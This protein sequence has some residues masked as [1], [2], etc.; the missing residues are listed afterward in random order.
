MSLV[1]GGPNLN[2]MS[3][4]MVGCILGKAVHP[5]INDIPEPTIRN[6]IQQVGNTFVLH[7]ITECVANRATYYICIRTM[8]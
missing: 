8:L 5:A 1:H 4:F 6:R 3:S 7:E 2:F